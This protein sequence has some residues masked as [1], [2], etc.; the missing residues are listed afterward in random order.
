MDDRTDISLFEVC[1]VLWSPVWAQERCRISPSHCLA[2][3]H[4]TRLNQASFFL[5]CF[6][7]FAFSGS[8]LVCSLSVFNLSSVLYFQACTN[9][10]GTV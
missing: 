9:V 1:G 4:K 5:L 10:N 7:L 3:G 2:E 8:C 6:M